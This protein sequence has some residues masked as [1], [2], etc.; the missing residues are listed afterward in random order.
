M[1]A[2]PRVL[3][4][5]LAAFAIPVLAQDAKQVSGGAQ[6]KTA[7]QPPTLIQFEEDTIEGG[8]RGPEVGTVV[9]R[10]RAE[11]ENLIKLRPS[12]HD[13]VLQSSGDL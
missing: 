7:P 9:S 8:L 11:Q 12:W 10:T 5:S 13:Q 3:L 6:S 4:L 1:L 2:I